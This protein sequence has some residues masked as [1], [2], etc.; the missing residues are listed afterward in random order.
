MTDLIAFLF[1]KW[2][3]TL[4]PMSLWDT[5]TPHKGVQDYWRTLPYGTCHGRDTLTDPAPLG[6]LP[7]GALSNHS[8]KKALPHSP[9]PRV[10]PLCFLSL[11]NRTLQICFSLYIASFWL[12][13]TH[14]PLLYSPGGVWTDLSHSKTHTHSPQTFM[15]SLSICAKGIGCFNFFPQLWKKC[16]LKVSRKILS[17]N[18][19]QGC[20]LVKIE[21]CV[22][23]KWLW[24]FLFLHIFF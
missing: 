2:A 20:S 24:G 4:S 13:H 5:S 17:E 21:Y 7:F 8:W 3:F 16:W 12:N 19:I 1:N 11:P 23:S 18:R 22:G 15:Q 9:T 6:P 14:F 10:T